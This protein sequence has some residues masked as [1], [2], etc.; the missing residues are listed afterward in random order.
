MASYRLQ[1]QALSVSSRLV[2][3][4][5]M[6]AVS[7]LAPAQEKDTSS[8]YAG[9]EAC[10][11]CHPTQSSSQQLTGHALSLSNPLAHRLARRFEDAP[12]KTLSEDIQVRFESED[13]AAVLATTLAGS[14]RKTIVDWAF[15]AGEQA[16]TFV[17]RVDEDW[18]LEH[19]WSY[20]IKAGHLSVTPGHLAVSPETLDEAVGISYRIFS[21]RTEIMSCF[22]CHS[23]GGIELMENYSIAVREPGVRCEACHGGGA[24]HIQAAAA[25]QLDLA[26]EKIRNPGRLTPVGMNTYCGVC[27]RPPQSERAAVVWN[28]PWNVRHQP[29]FLG[30]SQCF[31]VSENLRCIDCH[32][33]HEPLSNKQSVSYNDQCTDCHSLAK[34]PPAAVCPEPDEVACSECHMPKV[35][36][37]SEL[38]FTNHWIGVYEEDNLLVPRR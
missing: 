20:Y 26:I 35:R 1:V 5:V 36:P 12:M 4:L 10:Q 15:G 37:Q 17:S 14:E 32:D 9:A 21:P 34:R 19:R 23:T 29:V 11:A 33:P 31:Q 2:L 18:Y 24:A 8:A 16:V 13:G 25:G 6:S 27:H 28:D 3:F 38:A 22:G 30:R 7:G